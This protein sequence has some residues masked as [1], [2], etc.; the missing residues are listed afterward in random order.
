MKSIN[1]LVVATQGDLKTIDFSKF[2]FE[3]IKSINLIDYESM[4]ENIRQL[5]ECNLVV[6]YSIDSNDF[7]VKTLNVARILE[8]T[9]IHYSKIEEYVK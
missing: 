8:R 4:E 2:E 3:N 1:I 7:I 6:N 5:L 9:V